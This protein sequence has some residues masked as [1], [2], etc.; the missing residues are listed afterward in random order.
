M[1][2]ILLLFDT[3]T[4]IDI[5]HSEFIPQSKTVNK[6]YYLEILNIM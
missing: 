4:D 6:A 3:D 1:M 5:V 2:L